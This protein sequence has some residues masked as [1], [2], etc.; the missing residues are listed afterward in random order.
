MLV[1]AAHSSTASCSA[2]KQAK[3]GVQ[4]HFQLTF[5]S[6]V[7]KEGFPSKLDLAKLRFFPGGGMVDNYCLLNSLLDLLEGRLSGE[8]SQ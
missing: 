6:Q 4:H 1:M 3:S 7:T 2:P 8:A 5:H